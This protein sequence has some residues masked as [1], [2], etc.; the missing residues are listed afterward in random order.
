MMELN[1]QNILNTMKSPILCNLEKKNIPRKENFIMNT[2]LILRKFRSFLFNIF[3]CLTKYVIKIRN[4]I[5]LLKDLFRCQLDS[6][7]V[8]MYHN[9]LC[10]NGLLFFLFYSTQRS[11][12]YSSSSTISCVSRLC[13]LRVC[14]RLHHAY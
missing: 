10:N 14:A 5:Y 13:G 8:K 6:R 2:Y 3:G 12:D 9:K 11:I 7:L 4:L 1:S